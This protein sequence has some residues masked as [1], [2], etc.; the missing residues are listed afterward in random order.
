MRLGRLAGVCVIGLATAAGTLTPLGGCGQLASDAEGRVDLAVAE[1]RDFEVTTIAVGELAARNRVELRSGVEGQTNVVEVA[2]EG[3]RVE[4]GDVLVRLNSDSIVTEIEEDTLQ[5]D[6][7]NLDLDSAEAQYEIQVT[8]NEVALQKAKLDLRLAEIKLTQ[9]REG[10][11]GKRITEL[12]GALD[13]ASANLKRLEEKY[14]QSV[15]LNASNFLSDD[16]LQNDKIELLRAETTMKTAQADY[17]VYMNY[18]REQDEQTRLSERDNAQR[19]LEKVR[20]T[21]EV[22][23]KEKDARRQNQRVQV[24][25]RTQQL[26]RM[27][28]Q[29]EACTVLAPSAGLVVYGTTAEANGWRNQSEGPLQVGSQVRNNDLLIVLPDT[30]EMVANVKVHESL[31]GRVRPAQPARIKID[32]LGGAIVDGSVDTI[33]VLPESGGW[34][35]QNRREYSV[36]LTV[37]AEPELQAKLKPSMRV[38]TELVLDRVENALA[39]PVHAVFAEG[40]VRYVYTPEGGRYARTPVRLGKTSDLFAEIVDGLDAGDA[41]LTRRPEPGEVIDRE[42]DAQ[43]LAA[44]GY[45]SEPERGARRRS[46]SKPAKPAADAG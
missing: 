7:A 45:A 15:K 1:V 25:R 4:K 26:D 34:R 11:D 3:S 28:A 6:K 23:L 35:D 36:R 22:N 40:R 41:V 29:L 46:A 16:Q 14:A 30:S 37:N 44:L 43:R 5:L 18:Q 27:K 32:A 8:D 19:E 21:N 9:W 10:D 42:F 33:G 31:A 17:D 12:T 20:T 2:P 13:Q 39:V 24:S 38:E